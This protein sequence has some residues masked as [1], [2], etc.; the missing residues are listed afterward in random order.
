MVSE[1]LIG[2]IVE[3][4][5]PN[6]NLVCNRTSQQKSKEKFTKLGSLL[7]SV[8]NEVE[9]KLSRYLP[10]EPKVGNYSKKIKI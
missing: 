3:I 9:G 1:E 4:I 8:H 5:Y 10:E 2:K 6:L 7:I